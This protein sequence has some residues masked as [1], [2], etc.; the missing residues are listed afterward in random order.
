[1][2]TEQTFVIVGAGL[3]GAKAAQTLR[4]EGFT[5]G[6]TLVGAEAERPYERPPLSKG[7]LLGKE[8]RDKIYVHDEGWYGEHEVEPVLGTRVTAL[9]RGARRVELDGGRRLG[10]D[11]LLLATGA[12]PRRL[13]VPGAD[14]DGVHC[15][16]T[17]G[18]SERLREAI[19][20]GGRVVVVGAGW[21]GLETA[22]AAREYGC[23]VTVVEPRPVPLEASLG[24]EMGAFFAGVHREH[25]V[26]LRLGRGVTGFSGDGRVRAVALDDGTEIPADAVVVG[27]GARPNTGLAEQA[28]LAVENGVLVDAAL[29]TDDPHVYAAGDVARALNPLYGARIRVEHW[30]NALNGGPAAARSMLGLQVVYDRPPYFYT[31]QYEVGMEFTGWF[32]PGGYDEV[33]VRGDLQARD[34]HAFWLAGDRVVAGMHVNRWDEGI[35][36]VQDLIRTAAPVGRDRLADS[37]IPLGDLAKS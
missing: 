22:A 1:M 5:G 36:P 6:I 26:D 19:R 13:D 16:R 15:L 33:V 27:V 23:E 35:A 29:R 17:V 21:I 18:D 8:E 14:L 7:Y 30:A 4:E 10:Y 11:R 25:G 28:G 12:S 24:P 31:D 32:A 20:A 37:S 3:A 34:F 2:A 9:D